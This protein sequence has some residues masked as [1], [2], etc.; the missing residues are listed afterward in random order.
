M[1]ELRTERKHVSELQSALA[2]G[3]T[4][5]GGAHTHKCM[6]DDSSRHI[7]MQ[8]RACVQMWRVSPSSSQQRKC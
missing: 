5:E 8:F 4:S 7:D 2:L 1:Q 6:A 3:S